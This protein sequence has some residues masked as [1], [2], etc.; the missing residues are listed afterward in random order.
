MFLL[1][2]LFHADF[3]QEVSVHMGHSWDPGLPRLRVCMYYINSLLK[4]GKIQTI[5][6]LEVNYGYLNV[7][8]NYFH[9]WEQI[10]NC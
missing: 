3:L 8:V 7:N 6:G 10:E 9:I 2:S 5:L 1:P 4:N